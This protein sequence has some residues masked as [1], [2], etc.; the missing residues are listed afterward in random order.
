MTYEER[1]KDNQYKMDMF[2]L[3]QKL[4]PPGYGSFTII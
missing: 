4:P 2:K 1:T 3:K